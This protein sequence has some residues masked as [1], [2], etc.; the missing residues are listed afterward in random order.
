M[1]KSTP[2]PASSDTQP[3]DFHPA[4]ETW[5]LRRSRSLCNLRAAFAR[6]APAQTWPAPAPRLQDALWPSPSNGRRAARAAEAAPS[7]ELSSCLGLPL[8][9][10]PNKPGR[11]RCT[12]S[13]PRTDRINLKSKGPL[14]AHPTAGLILRP[15]PLSRL[16]LCFLVANPAKAGV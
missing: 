12:V 6:A 10:P 11:K 5:A 3:L 15:F 13:T 9:W 14:P 8:P 1:V 16:W 4:G 7:S 2:G